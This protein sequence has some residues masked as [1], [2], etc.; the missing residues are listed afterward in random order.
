MQVRAQLVQLSSNCAIMRSPG[1]GQGAGPL[2]SGLRRTGEK[3]GN[4]GAGSPY[5]RL[6]QQ[7]TMLQ[8][9]HCR[10]R[11]SHAVHNSHPSPQLVPPPPCNWKLAG[12]SP[13]PVCCLLTLRPWPVLPAGVAIRS[14]AAAPRAASQYRS[15]QI[16]EH[17]LPVSPDLLRRHYVEATSPSALP[18]PSLCSHLIP[19]GAAICLLELV[20]LPPAAYPSVVCK[21]AV[22]NLHDGSG[23]SLQSVAP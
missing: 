9:C 23:T 15:P 17:S 14:S 5:M 3:P 20:Q 22:E 13:L 10:S 18:L 7:S 1:M 6:G 12:P 21:P 19:V 2:E 11:P 4:D 8:W 16:P